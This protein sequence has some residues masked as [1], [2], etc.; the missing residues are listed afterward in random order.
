MKASRTKSMTSQ[1]VMVVAL[2]IVGM[3]LY[4]FYLSREVL[5]IFN[6]LASM[7]LGAYFQK[8]LPSNDNKDDL[9]Q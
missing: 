3:Q 2:S 7:A 6:T 1:I 4:N 8:S 9:S 5:D